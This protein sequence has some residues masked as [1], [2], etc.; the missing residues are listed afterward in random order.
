MST[1]VVMGHV[2]WWNT[3]V[4]TDQTAE[5]WVM[6]SIVVSGFS[7]SRQV[8][9]R[10]AVAWI[11]GWMWDTLTDSCVYSW[12]LVRL[13]RRFVLETK[14]PT[15]PPVIT[16]TSTTTS[17]KPPRPPSPPGP[18]RVD[19]ATCQSGECIPRDYICDGQRDCSDG[20][21]E[22]RCGA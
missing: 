15:P 8:V 4:T 10:S 1:G 3:C 6:R 2:S 20:S 9:T 18:C 19:Q 22:F 12:N 11:A 21:D 14:R 13:I 16:T 7:F 17:R 5:T